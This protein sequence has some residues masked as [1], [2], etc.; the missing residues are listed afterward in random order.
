M[1]VTPGTGQQHADRVGG[2]LHRKARHR[3]QLVHQL[4]SL[5]PQRAPLPEGTRSYDLLAPPQRLRL[6][7]EQRLESDDVIVRHLP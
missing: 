1:H 3:H 7:V 5:L 4:L 6:A 2:V